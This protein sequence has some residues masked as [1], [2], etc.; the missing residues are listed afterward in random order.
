MLTY[1]EW[2]PEGAE[3]HGVSE[4]LI[5]YKKTYSEYGEDGWTTTITSAGWMDLSGKQVIA[6]D[7]DKY[8]SWEDF[9]NGRAAVFI[10]KILKVIAAAH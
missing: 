4:G 9:S 8:V 5:S 7:S 6:I 3:I 1:N 10:S 2:L